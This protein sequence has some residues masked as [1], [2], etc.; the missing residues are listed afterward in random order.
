MC[1]FLAYMGRKILLAELLTRPGN[2]LI[3]QSY[4]SMERAEPLN[5]DGFGVGWYAPE[6][7][8]TPCVF[9]SLT[10][11]WN[12]RNLRR[13]AEKVSTS[14]LFAH[15]RAAP[16]DSLVSE[17]NCHPFQY[18]RFLWM[19]N[20]A[21]A[22]FPAIKRRLRESLRDDLYNLVQGTTD[23]EHAFAV[24]LNR[25]ADPMANYSPEVLR[26]A[27]VETIRQLETWNR[28]AGITQPSYYNFA[29]TDGNTVLATRY[30]SD[31][32]QEPASLF[33]SHGVKFECHEGICRMVP[34][35]RHEHAVI[36]ASEP[37]TEARENWIAVPENHLVS[38]TSA[39]EVEV[40]KI[41]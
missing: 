20:G 32:A 4:K 9:T 19:H 1:R 30:V 31:P 16:P 8:P 12:N 3:K 15:V 35:S 11:A 13:L 37:L 14:C 24:F 27:L 22:Q 29:L 36:I 34:A 5:G 6:A 17:V 38:A 25:I 26:R 23:S 39:L 21:S 10:P 33:L 40:R 41:G 2:S 28:E 7:D 18:G